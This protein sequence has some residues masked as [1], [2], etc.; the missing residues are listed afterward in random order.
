MITRTAERWRVDADAHVT[1]TTEKDTGESVLWCRSGSQL[2]T[3]AAMV[4][5]ELVGEVD[6]VVCFAPPE[7]LFG[8]LF[9]VELPRL[10]NVPVQ[11]LGTDPVRAMRAPRLRPGSRV[12]FVCL[13]ASWFLLERITAQIAALGGAV[14]LHGNG[15][16]TDA[17]SRVMAA[18]RGCPVKAFELYGSGETGGIAFRPIDGPEA[19]E[20]EDE[21]WALLPDV[22][23]ATAKPGVTDDWMRLGVRSPR[24]ARRADQPQAPDLMWLN[25][26][27]RSAG[28]RS[29]RFHAMSLGAVRDRSGTVTVSQANLTINSR[30]A[31]A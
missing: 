4:A 22:D 7:G 15:P 10:L 29:F 13:P 1:V 11:M 19:G 2:R 21:P 20:G 30:P 24:L 5:R 9:G 8:R 25:D 27:I 23:L 3:E 6:E 14:L 17:T 12:L 16:T 28:Q 31:V 18:L 26:I